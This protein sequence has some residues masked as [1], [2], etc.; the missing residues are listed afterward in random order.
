MP[1]NQQLFDQLS[2]LTGGDPTLTNAFAAGLGLSG[3]GA[4]GIDPSSGFF[5]FGSLGRVDETQDPRLTGLLDKLQA[6]LGGVKRDSTTNEAITNLMRTQTSP[7]F[8]GAVPEEIINSLRK[9]ISTAGSPTTYEQEV[10]D[11]RRAGLDGLTAQENTA[12]REQGQAGLDR[13]FQ[14]NLRAGLAQNNLAG[15]QGGANSNLLRDLNL[16]SLQ[17]NRGLSRDILLANID[18][19]NRRLNEYQ[20]LATGLSNRAFDRRLQGNTALSGILFNRDTANAQ[21]RLSAA[22]AINQNLLD[23]QRFEESSRANRYAT[24]GNTLFAAQQDAL[25]RRLQNLNQ[26]AKEKQGQIGLLF[27]SGQ[28]GAA[29]QAQNRSFDLAQQGLNSI[30]GF[31]I[32]EITIPEFNFTPISSPIDSGGNQTTPTSPGGSNNSSVSIDSSTW[33]DFHPRLQ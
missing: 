8:Q 31:E 11:R 5:G 24:Y 4:P 19:R 1:Y 7:I 25:N 10:I 12:L 26:L 2:A 21:Q 14:T 28:F 32:P 13:A 33:S 3:L 15:R 6:D 9:Q 22:E 27:G 18:E 17:A 20:D 23:R 16:D 29:Q 30:Q